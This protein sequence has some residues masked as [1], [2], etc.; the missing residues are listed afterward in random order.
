MRCRL[1]LREPLPGSGQ[2]PSAGRTREDNLAGFIGRELCDV[3]SGQ[4][5]QQSTRDP[6][7]G[8][9]GRLADINQKDASRSE[10]LF[11]LFGVVFR[12]LV[13]SHVRHGVRLKRCSS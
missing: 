8:V 6:F 10:K 12:Y 13:G 4:R 1:S 5:V 11:D 9:L 3:E 2:G 7:G